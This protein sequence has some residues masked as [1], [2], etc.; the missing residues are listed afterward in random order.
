MIWKN[1]P[2]YNLNNIF[3]YL[4][5][6][7]IYICKSEYLF[8]YLHTHILLRQDDLWLNY[9]I[10]NNGLILSSAKNKKQSMQWSQFLV[11]FPWNSHKYFRLTILETKWK[12]WKLKILTFYNELREHWQK[13]SVIFSF[14]YLYLII[15]KQKLYLL[16]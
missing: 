6:I 8:F 13:Y 16:N 9:K 7:Y 3:L 11:P 5:H 2:I 12:L 1:K 14:N 10:L 4:S 15:L